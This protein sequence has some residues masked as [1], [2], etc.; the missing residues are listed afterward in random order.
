MGDNQ[1]ITVSGIVIAHTSKAL[2]LDDGCVQGWIPYS[3]IDDC[4]V[5]DI[6]KVEVGDSVEVAIPAWLARDK[7]F[8]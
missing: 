2:L 6:E 7:E 3:V 1:Y 4:N 8:I 5:D